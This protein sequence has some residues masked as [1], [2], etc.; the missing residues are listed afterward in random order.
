MRLYLSPLAYV[1]VCALRCLALHGTEWAKAQVATIRLRLL[2]IAAR[3][4]VT[5]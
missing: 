4:R 3:V 5:A 1:L 2:K